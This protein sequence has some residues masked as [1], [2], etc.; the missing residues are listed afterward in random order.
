MLATEG[1]AINEFQGYRGDC[2]EYAML[3]A[4]HALDPEHYNLDATTLDATTRVAIQHYG[5]GATGAEPLSA[6]EQELVNW[7]GAKVQMYPYAE[8]FTTD[9]QAILNAHGGVHPVIIECANAGR[10]PGDESG[11]HYHFICQLNRGQFADGDNAHLGLQSYTD[12]MLTIAGVCG[13]IVVLET[14]AQEVAPAPAPTRPTTGM[15]HYTVQPGDTL[16]SIAA[17]LH[18]AN[19]YHQLYAPNMATIEAAARAHHQPDSNSG[20]LIY[21]GTVLEYQV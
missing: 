14:H 6:I 16:S 13:L 15:A 2:G 11:V 9:W 3:A 17:K 7:Y 20:N 8:P 18:L 10:L 12:E 5:A 19:W 1:Y 21:A 4:L